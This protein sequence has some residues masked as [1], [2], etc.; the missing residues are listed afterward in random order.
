MKT[1]LLIALGAALLSGVVYAGTPHIVVT[2]PD[3]VPA[4]PKQPEASWGVELSAANVFATGNL[5]GDNS[6][7]FNLAGPELTAVRTLSKNTSFTLRGSALYG[8]HAHASVNGTNSLGKL[9]VSLLP[10]IRYTH[11]LNDQVSLFAGANAGLVFTDV[12][13]RHSY[14]LNTGGRESAW[15]LG[16]SAEVGVQYKLNEQWSLLAAY[17]LSGDTARPTVYEKKQN[18]QIYNGVRVGVG[19]KF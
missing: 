15:G 1:S 6:T 9:S 8:R 14:L 11:A 19:L 10:G 12:N 17:Q 18:T 13:K 2:M 5:M 3:T 16:L 7:R 4:P